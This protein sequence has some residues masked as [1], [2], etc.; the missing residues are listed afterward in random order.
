MLAHPRNKPR[1][2]SRRLNSVRTPVTARLSGPKSAN[3]FTLH[4]FLMTLAFGFFGPVASVL[5]YVL[6]DTCKL[7][8]DLVKWVHGLLQLGAVVAS[9]LGFV[10][11]ELNRLPMALRPLVW[12][13]G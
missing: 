11:V 13:E 9:V 1:L 12:A 2:A 3:F 7:N 5:Y 6:E 8:H 4:M 10:Q